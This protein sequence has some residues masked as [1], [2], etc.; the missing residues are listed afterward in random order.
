MIRAYHDARGDT[1]RREIIVPD[2]AHGT[3][4]A[5]AALAGYEV[6]PIAS[7]GVLTLEEVAAHMTDEVAALVLRDNYFQTQALSVCRAMAP[8]LLDEQVRFMRF[9]EKAGRLDPAIEFLPNEDEIAQRKARGLGLTA[10]EQAVLLAYSKMWLSDEMVDSELPEDPWIASALYRYFPK[11]LRERFGAYIPR[12]PLRRE[13]VATHVVNSMVNRVGPTFTHRLIEET[14]AAAPDIVRAY[15][16]TRQVF[17]L[18]SLW[19]ANDA[20]GH[21]VDY[22][23]H[24]GIVLS[25]LQ[26]I[27]RGTVWLLHERDAL[28]DLDATIRRFAPGVAD[29]GAGLERWLVEG[30]RQALVAAARR[31]VE[32]KVPAP[33]AQRVARLD[34]QLAGFDIVEVGSELGQPVETVARVYFGVGGRLAL[35]WLS[36][37]IV[38]LPSRSHW[39][40]LA[41][42][43]MRSD[44]SSLARELARSVLKDAG[45]ERDAP[46]L[47]ERWESQR[48]FRLDRCHQL[49]A[50]LQPLARL[51]QSMLS[52]LLRE[53]RA[54]V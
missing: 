11:A 32:A 38:A 24:N 46:T 29:V 19:Q 31:L 16:G 7:Q 54:L 1:A 52:V 14:G 23:T 10:P 4:P 44:L 3:N 47:I 48:R 12:H 53:L 5:T 42:L 15:L 37:Q 26:L 8:E 20:L 50:D 27:E 22:A 17:D 40:G 30:E 28:Q 41:R 51:D 33:L 13:I 36:Q 39:Q 49:L 34:A 18:V 45:A 35:G 6:V 43:A 25:T 2:A 21:E 9:L